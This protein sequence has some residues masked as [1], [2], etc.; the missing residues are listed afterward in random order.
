MIIH[1][2]ADKLVEMVNA[3][4]L[5]DVNNQFNYLQIDFA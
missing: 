5:N 2:I 1:F 4:S 3:G